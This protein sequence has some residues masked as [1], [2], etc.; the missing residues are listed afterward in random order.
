[1]ALSLISFRGSLSRRRSTTLTPSTCDLMV[2]VISLLC[3]LARISTLCD[4]YHRRRR[5]FASFGIDT[6]VVVIA[7]PRAGP[8]RGARFRAKTISDTRFNIQTDHHQPHVLATSSSSRHP[9]PCLSLSHNLN[10]H[11]ARST[12]KPVSPES[13]PARHPSS[14]R[15]PT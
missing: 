7:W 9:A 12:S 2:S 4:R 15:C 1:M 5:S 13:K 11:T 6:I 14:Q 10:I 8:V 3:A